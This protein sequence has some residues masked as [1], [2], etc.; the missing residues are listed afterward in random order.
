MSIVHA[1]KL[2]NLGAFY[3]P[4][5]VNPDNVITNLSSITFSRREKWLLSFGLEHCS[6]SK[7]SKFNLLL[8]MESMADRLQGHPI[9]NN[10]NFNHFIADLKTLTNN[11]LNIYKT[12]K[13]DMPTLFNQQD[14]KILENLKNNKNIII[15]RP[16]KG[17]GVVNLDKED[18]V[19]KMNAILNDHTT[20]E[21]LSHL[22]PL[23]NNF[24][25]E[26][27]VGS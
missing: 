1:H 17:R 8:C 27:K 2:H 19:T 20:F 23:K 13:N 6:I 18:Y 12:T 14:L 26:D 5:T 4:P 3:K 16:D 11:S 25:R 21:K 24:L 9:L 22:D 10:T 15:C 7:P